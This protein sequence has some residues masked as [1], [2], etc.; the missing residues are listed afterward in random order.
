[1]VRIEY[2]VKGVKQ[3]SGLRQ[4][5]QDLRGKYSA[6]VVKHGFK[7]AQRNM[8]YYQG[9]LYRALRYETSKQ[10]SKLIQEQPKDGQD[11]P[12]HLWMHGIGKYN[13]APY[14]TS[15]DPDYMKTVQSIMRKKAIERARAKLK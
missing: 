6:E 10:S 5:R 13:I 4:L 7:W 11:R 12:Y 2:R 1:M 8:P 3:K 14:I 9:D 15:G